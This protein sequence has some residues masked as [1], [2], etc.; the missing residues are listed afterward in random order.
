MCGTLKLNGVTNDAIRL[1][2]FPFSLRDRAKA[3]IYSIPPGTVR[4]WDQLTKAFLGKY[5]PTSKTVQLRNQ[6]SSFMQKDGESLYEAWERFKELLRMCP[7]HGLEKW[8]RVQTFYNGLSPNTK[9]IVDAAAGGCLTM[10]TPDES[11]Q[12]IEDMAQNH[13]QW[14]PERA[15]PNRGGKHDVDAITALSAKL[16]AMTRKLDNLSV[17]AVGSNQ[18]EAPCELC[19]VSGHGP[20]ECQQGMPLSHEE[21]VEQA[22]LLGKDHTGKLSIR[23]FW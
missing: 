2:L 15:A 21:S 17:N 23:T 3:W 1:I 10:K 12:L 18:L 22:N 6:I 20:L 11:Y 9:L 5:F 4:T 8:L 14:N 7:H 16:D 19:G 13:Q